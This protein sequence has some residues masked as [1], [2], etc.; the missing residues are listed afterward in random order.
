MGDPNK[1]DQSSQRGVMPFDPP[2]NWA[3]PPSSQSSN[4]G[5]AIVGIEF[6]SCPTCIPFIADRLHLCNFPL[7]GANS[8]ADIL[9]NYTAVFTSPNIFY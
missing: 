3:L 4:D 1:A 2:E 7:Q 9:G 5:P 8:S 6:G